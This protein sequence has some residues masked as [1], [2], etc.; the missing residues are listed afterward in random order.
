VSVTD[1]M[2]R[3]LLLTPRK[4]DYVLTAS[5]ARFLGRLGVDV[6]ASRRERRAFAHHCLDWSECRAHLA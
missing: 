5:G 6:D 3:R 4:H 1:A 2:V